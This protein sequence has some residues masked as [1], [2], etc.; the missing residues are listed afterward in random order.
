MPSGGQVQPYPTSS[1]HALQ[2]HRP[3]LKTNGIIQSKHQNERN[4]LEMA[5]KHVG[6]TSDRIGS[7]QNVDRLVT[8]ATHGRH[9]EG[10]VSPKL[11]QHR[12]GTPETVKTSSAGK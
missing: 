12:K 10:L 1:Q 8:C 2:Q 6:L 7:H 4:R 11:S 9:Q 5:A 3:R